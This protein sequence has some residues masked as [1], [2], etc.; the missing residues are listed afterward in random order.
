MP[1]IRNIAVGLPLKQGHVL[2][3]EGRDHVRG[4]DFLRAIGGGIEFGEPADEALHREFMEE[5]GMQL[6]AVRLLGVRENIF[7]YE[8]VAGHEIAHIFAVQSAELDAVP[9]DAE[10]HVL[11]EGSPVRWV[12]V[13]E[14]LDGRRLLFPHG[15]P[16]LL[17][18]LRRD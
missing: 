14:I 15:A 7:V 16:Q 18:A 17:A 2:V 8:G 5:L 6:E 12:P 4:R 11:D 9:L 1:S 13:E 10:L 3:L